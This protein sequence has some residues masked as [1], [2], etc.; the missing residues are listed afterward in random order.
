MYTRASGLV[1][2][3]PKTAVSTLRP[4]V[5]LARFLITGIGLPGFSAFF[6]SAGS[7]NHK[8]DVD[9]NKFLGRPGTLQTLP[10]T[11][12]W[13]LFD[14]GARALLLEEVEHFWWTRP[15]GTRDDQWITRRSLPPAGLTVA[16]DSRLEKVH[17]GSIAPQRRMAACEARRRT[18]KD[19]EVSV[20][21]VFSRNAMHTER[22][23]R[24]LGRTCSANRENDVRNL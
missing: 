3:F 13:H 14:C 12:G 11:E 17:M 18:R 9:N 19:F 20:A 15:C 7:S 6:R 2:L 5:S 21:D 10:S 23:T 1:L 16:H 22:S 4:S 8:P 24:S